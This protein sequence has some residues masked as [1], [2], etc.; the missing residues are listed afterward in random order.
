MDHDEAIDR[1]RTPGALVWHYTNLDT[2]ALILRSNAL[3]ATEVGFQNDIRETRTADDAFVAAL[4]ELTG[5]AKYGLFAAHALEM[6]DDLSSG[7][8]R[9]PSRERDLLEDAR[10]ILC[11]S[12][13]PDSLYAWRT[14]ASGG[15]GCA[16]GLDPSVPLGVVDPR[17]GTHRMRH[18]RKVLYQPEE[19]RDIS[20]KVLTT[21]GHRWNIAKAEETE[22][23]KS[24]SAF[25]LLLHE[26]TV[27][28][29]H[30]RAYAKDVS[31][32][33]E[34]EQRITLETVSLDAIMFTPSSMG[35]RP[36]VQIVGSDGHRFGL[37]YPTANEARK[38]PIR[39]MRLA[40]G[41]PDSAVTSTEWLLVTHGYRLDPDHR[42]EEDDDGEFHDWEEWTDSVV[43]DRSSHPY[44]SR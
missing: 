25:I 24:D 31:F 4:N 26:L 11:A 32:E 36:H 41:A 12:D 20:L 29:S 37:S 3:L 38:L 15:I 1:A 44:R 18:W 19:I 42:V 23:E 30:V 5:H 10:F 27:A 13:D 9:L 17:E 22:A 8:V 40:P 6:L 28:R 14:Y 43:I 34:H 21:L 2:L 33:E 7:E 35:P 39:A 16:I